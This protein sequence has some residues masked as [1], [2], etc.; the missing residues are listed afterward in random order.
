MS[1]ALLRA[2]TGAGVNKEEAAQ[3]VIELTPQYFDKPEVI[4]QKLDAIPVYIES[5]KTRANIKNTSNQPVQP[6]ENSA[7]SKADILKQ[8][9]L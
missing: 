8:Y 2:A 1:E 6:A 7:R 9:G 5:L 4:Q 3:K